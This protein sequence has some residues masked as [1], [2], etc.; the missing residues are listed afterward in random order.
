VVEPQVLVP[1]RTEFGKEIRKDYENGNVKISRHDMTEMKPREDGIANTLTSVQKDNLVVCERR[2]DEGVRFFEDGC[3]GAIRTYPSGGAKRVIEQAEGIRV[4]K[5][6]PKECYR[7]MGWKDE[8]ID[9]I[10]K[11]GISKTQQYKQAGN[12]IVVQVLEAIFR[13]L[14]ENTNLTED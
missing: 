4:R 14:F 7:L 6:T 1:K 11:A 3:I 12:G 2:Y 5:L 9:K 13:Q 8:Q 10:I